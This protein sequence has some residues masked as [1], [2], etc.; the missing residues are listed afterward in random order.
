MLPDTFSDATWVSSV[1]VRSHAWQS[2]QKF[3]PRGSKQ[4]KDGMTVPHGTNFVEG[5]AVQDKLVIGK[6]SLA[7]FI[8]LLGE[9]LPENPVFPPGVDGVLGLARP[10]SPVTEKVNFWRQV[11]KVLV[12]PIFGIK[13]CPRDDPSQ[14]TGEIVLGSVCHQ[15]KKGP[16]TQFRLLPG[17]Y[18]SFEIEQVKVNTW[19]V[20]A[21]KALVIMDTST[22][23]ILGP[24]RTV[25]E[26][27]SMIDPVESTGTFTFVNCDTWLALPTI[28]FSTPLNE[29]KLTPKDYVIKTTDGKCMSAF[30]S[31]KSDKRF[32]RF[33]IAAHRHRYV[34]YNEHRKLVEFAAAKC[35]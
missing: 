34:I 27:N 22:G 12:I 20:D 21:Q 3:D 23:Y 29:L 26:I 7:D 31:S 2:R 15:C 35:P 14:G 5:R 24:E 32:W 30:V 28:S 19:V 6:Q 9:K 16:I 17:P 18:W 33:G 8:F 10:S 25:T 4:S 1:T 13:L 11:K